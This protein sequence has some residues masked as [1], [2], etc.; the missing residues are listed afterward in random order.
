ML[1]PVI[2]P[3]AKRPPRANASGRDW[4]A[5]L[6]PKK[7]D[8]ERTLTAT[9]INQF[10]RISRNGVSTARSDLATSRPRADRDTDGRR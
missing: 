3:T 1:M 8:P 4:P 2:P 6:A 7:I 5:S 9:T 10:V